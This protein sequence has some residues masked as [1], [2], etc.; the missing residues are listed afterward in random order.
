MDFKLFKSSDR[1]SFDNEWVKT[2]HYFSFAR[3]YDP[4]KTNF[5]MLR[6]INEDHIQ[7]GH[8]YEMHDHD[9]MELI[10]IPLK[11]NLKQK[12]SNKNESVLKVGD[13]SLISAG[14]GMTHSEFNASMLD[15]LTM[16][17]IWILPLIE[18]EAPRYEKINLTDADI[19]NKFVLFASPQGG[20]R[21]LA[22]NQ[23]AYLSMGLFKSG[24]NVEY[25]LKRNQNCLFAL[26]LDGKVKVGDYEIYKGDAL[27][28][29]NLTAAN[30]EFIESSKVLLIEV[31]NII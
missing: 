9:N 20:W 18:D 2:W 13:I 7:P 30:F 17:Q 8:G 19:R 24:K 3:Y 29:N 12:D 22:I 28:M 11:G 14:D 1:G 21:I 6:A 10:T 4:Q 26:V 27:G 31:P 15:E 23:N 5:G 25:K 16:L